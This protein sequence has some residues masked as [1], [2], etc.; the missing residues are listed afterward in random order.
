MSNQPHEPTPRTTL[1]SIATVADR[2]DLSKDT[3]RRLIA[4]GE[5]IAIR[6]GSNVRVDAAELESFL[7]R[8]RGAAFRVPHAQAE[9]D[10]EPI[11]SGQ[12]HPLGETEAGDRA[13]R[14]TDRRGVPDE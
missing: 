10:T 12:V 7:D 5:L 3:V 8:R 4:Q 11:D 9:A 14:F 1:Y 2:L 6:I 13:R